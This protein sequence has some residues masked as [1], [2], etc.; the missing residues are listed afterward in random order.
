MKAIIIGATGAT[1]K[2]LVDLLLQD[3][4]F[5]AIS[6]FVRRPLSISDP[7]IETHI[8]D[9]EKIDSWKSEIQGDVL[10]SCLGTTLKA[11]GSQEAQWKVDYDYQFNF[12]KSAHENGVPT[13]VL[14][15]SMGAN[16]RSSIFYMKM[17]GQLEEAVKL[18]GFKNVIIVRPPSLI[19]KDTDRFGEKI[20]VFA[21]NLL[22]KVGIMRSMAPMST[23]TVAKAMLVCGLHAQGQQVFE[24]RE[25]RLMAGG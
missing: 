18:L 9:F 14:M 25:L 16:S 13:L 19:R 3:T 21:L 1:G 17:K 24:S 20:G 4:A 23:E 22:N 2:D 7:M 5:D 6:V 11:A 8:V 12:A 15:S 10:F